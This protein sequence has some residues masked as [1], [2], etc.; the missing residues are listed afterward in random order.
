MSPQFKG[1][2]SRYLNKR[3]SFLYELNFK[4][5]RKAEAMN[6]IFLPSSVDRRDLTIFFNTAHKFEFVRLFK[7]V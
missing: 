6:E 5:Q 4:G 2:M 1:F 3:E 7:L